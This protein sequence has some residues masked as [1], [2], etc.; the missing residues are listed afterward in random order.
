MKQFIF[1]ISISIIFISSCQKEVSVEQ[2]TSGGSNSKAKIKSYNEKLTSSS[3]NYS[4]TFNIGYDSKDRFN[5]MVSTSNSGDKFLYSYPSSSKYTLD[6][7]N[8]GVLSI[9]VDFFLNNSSYIDSTFQFNDTQDTTTE[10]YLYN[11]SNQ[12]VKVKEYIYSKLTGS[13]LDMTTDYTYDSNN[14]LIKTVD[15]DKNIHTYEYYSNLIYVWPLIRP[16]NPGEDLK[17]RLI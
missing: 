1:T 13:N 2:S 10:K 9:H 4:L 14:N 17:R 12:L 8:S 6:L 5:S 3:E 11:S 16:I 7:Y 15:T